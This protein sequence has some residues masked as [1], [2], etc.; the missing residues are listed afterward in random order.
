MPTPFAPEHFAS[1]HKAQID[2]LLTLAN[3]AFAGMERLAALNLNVARSL[4]EDGAGSARALLEAK[5]I[6]SFMAIQSGLVQPAVDKAVAW[7]RSAYAISS[8]TGD[9]LSKTLETQL[10]EAGQ[11]LDS[12]L[13]AL[14]KN[15]PAG[16][17]AAVSAS[18][19]ALKSA[20]G[21]AG[22]AY[23]TFSKAAR[24]A[25]EFAESNLAPAAKPASK[26]KKAA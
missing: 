25:S 23:E 12:S 18:V 4:A 5:D 2:G 17:D 9:A 24:Q 13:D 20:L 21:A 14:A 26:T 3:T 1:V 22:T 16:A 11:A 8:T 10:A 19:G 6:Q 7:S 15:A